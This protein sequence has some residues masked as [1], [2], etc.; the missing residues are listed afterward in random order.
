MARIDNLNNFLT[1]VANAIR[2][3]TGETEVINASDFD[4]KISTISAAYET[5]S[6]TFESEYINNYPTANIEL[7]YR[8]KAIFFVGTVWSSS[9]TIA[10][11][12]IGTELFSNVPTSISSWAGGFSSIEGSGNAKTTLTISDTGFTIKYSKSKSSGNYAIAG[13]YMVVK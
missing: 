10:G 4:T 7:G 13:T 6:G 9:Y 11:F 1:D 2:N 8:P 5:E 12:Y 3:K